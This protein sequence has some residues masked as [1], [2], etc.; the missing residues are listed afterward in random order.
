MW[1][2]FKIAE[3]KEIHCREKC[4]CPLSKQLKR[5]E[6]G[7]QIWVCWCVRGIYHHNLSQCCIYMSS[8]CNGFTLLICPRSTLHQIARYHRQ[9]KWLGPTAAWICHTE[10][11]HARP[12]IS[13]LVAPTS[14][15]SNK[16]SSHT[17]HPPTHPR[18]CANVKWPVL[19]HCFVS[20]WTNTGI[21][22]ALWWKMT[23]R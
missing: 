23:A 10:M 15:S 11:S 6:A 21:A 14:V 7:L 19:T 17:K 3:L 9:Q 5:L 20:R 18:Q 22:L 16:G 2:Y 4:F 12:V 13:S 8:I 1:D